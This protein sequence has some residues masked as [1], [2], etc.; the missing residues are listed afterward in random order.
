MTKKEKK[1]NFIFNLIS[2][3]YSKVFFIQ[4]R[5]LHKRLSKKLNHFTLN[6]T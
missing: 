2:E 3:R 5:A 4:L 1:K 6:N